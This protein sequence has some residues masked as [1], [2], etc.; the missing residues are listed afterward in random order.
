[1][2]WS[3]TKAYALGLSGV[4]LNVKGRESAGIVEPGA[5]AGALERELVGK[6]SKMRDEELG[7]TAIR[8]AY[9]TKSLYKGPY[10]EAGPD[11]IIGYNAGYRTAWD[12]ATGKVGRK[13]IEDNRKAWSGDHSVDPPLVPGV[14]FS[15][16]RIDSEDPGIEDLAP[17]ALELFGIERPEWMEGKPVFRWA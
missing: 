16:R 17:T 14:L 5:E 11:L 13:V 10:L 8:E 4:Y 1:V 12:A 2:D 9:A 6:L 3:R 7:E 15:N